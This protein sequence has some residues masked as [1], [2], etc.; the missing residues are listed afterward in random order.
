M[1][2]FDQ[3]LASG[4]YAFNGELNSHIV[5]MAITFFRKNGKKFDK[6]DLIMKGIKKYMY[7]DVIS[8]QY[9][10]KDGLEIGDLGNYINTDLIALFHNLKLSR[11]RYYSGID[12]K[13]EPTFESAMK[14]I[15]REE[16][17]EI[18]NNSKRM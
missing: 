11:D 3:L 1:N 12:I 5:R 8:K 10:L 2:F 16:P 9:K 17:F 13:E 15:V 14:S 6:E 18:V 4:Y 7:F